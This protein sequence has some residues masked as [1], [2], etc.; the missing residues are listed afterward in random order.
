MILLGVTGLLLLTIAAFFVAA[1]IVSAIRNLL[2]L[3][4][5]AGGGRGAMAAILGIALLPVVFLWRKFMS[6]CG[7][8]TSGPEG[9]R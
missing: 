3:D 8:E 2:G 9:R 7:I 1:L 4:G 5:L 6:W